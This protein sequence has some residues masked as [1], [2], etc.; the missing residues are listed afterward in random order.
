MLA[1][2]SSEKHEAL[3]QNACSEYMCTALNCTDDTDV[4]NWLCDH[5]QVEPKGGVMTS[6]KYKI[7]KWD[8]FVI[9]MFQNAASF[10]DLVI[11][12]MQIQRYEK[13]E[14][15]HRTALNSIRYTD[16]HSFLLFVAYTWGSCVWQTWQI[17]WHNQM[18]NP[19]CTYQ[20]GVSMWPVTEYGS[21][22]WTLTLCIL[23]HLLIHTLVTSHYGRSFQQQ[24]C[25]PTLHLASY[26]DLLMPVFVA[27]MGEGL[28]KL[29]TCS[30]VP[31]HWMNVW[32][33]STF[34]EKP[35]VKAL[36]RTTEQRSSLRDVSWV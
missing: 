18:L 36:L 3:C 9:T 20:C 28:I 30:D 10:P 5:E 21:N 7:P 24:K 23:Y 27:N 6:A 34:L 32:R 2:L 19:T 17:D 14:K 26:P 35:Q 16:R 15:Q 25:N 29:I 22:Q 4:I 13:N 8:Y 12:K 1:L 31:G 33:N 11:T